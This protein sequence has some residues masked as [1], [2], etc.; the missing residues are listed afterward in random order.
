[1]K[2]ACAA[3]MVSAR[4]LSQLEEPIE[5]SVEFWFTADEEIGGADGARWLSES[6]TFQG[7]VCVI[8]DGNGGGNEN[9][10]IDLGCKGGTATTLVA[11][12][13]TA[14]GS[15]PHLGENAISKLIKAIPWVERIADYRLELPPELD[16][17]VE[18]SIKFYLENH[19]IHTEEQREATRRLFNYPTVTCNI[20]HA[21]VKRNVVP[22][23]A[24]A[25]FDIRLTPGSK[26]LKVKDRIE[27]LVKESGIPG[28]EVSVRAGKTA[29]YHESPDS[30]FADKFAETI[31]SVTGKSPVFKILTG[32]TD[33]IAIKNFTGIPCLGYG[34][35]LTGMA[36]QP[37][38]YVTVENLVLGVKVYAGF[39]LLY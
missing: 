29:G 7:E 5:N 39:P 10:S 19:D 24:E 34:T 37:D 20:I 21:G 32:G 22:D 8:G 6:K 23:Y 35:S 15:T 11:R 36:H 1:M 3:A 13:K 28:L 26:P 38:E 9:P 30:V 2:G 18:S 12:G 33:A 4:I 14:H 27:E 31:E 17:P 16:G 25:E